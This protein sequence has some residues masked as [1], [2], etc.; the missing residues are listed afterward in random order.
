MALR[1]GVAVGEGMCFFGVELVVYDE[2]I[3]KVELGLS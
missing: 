3:L 2:S 1:V